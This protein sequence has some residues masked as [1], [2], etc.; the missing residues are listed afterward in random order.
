MACILGLHFHFNFTMYLIP[1]TSAELLRQVHKIIRNV[2]QSFSCIEQTRIYTD[3]SLM[4]F[5]A[6][7]NSSYLYI[8]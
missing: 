4:Y 7:R 1:N 5:Q 2:L 3:E 6:L 8:I